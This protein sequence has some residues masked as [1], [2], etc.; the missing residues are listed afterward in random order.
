MINY[1]TSGS[2]ALLR[3]ALATQTKTQDYNDAIAGY[4]YGL[5]AKTEDDFKQYNDYLQ[6]R[7]KTLGPTDPSKALTLQ[8]SSDAA[9]SSYNSAEIGRQTLAVQYGDETNR[10][11]YNKIQDLLSAAISN[12]DDGLAA[13]L[14]ET[15]ATLS[16]TI[17]NEDDAA[18]ASG[19]AGAASAAAAQTTKISQAEASIDKAYQTGSPLMIDGQAKPLN[20]EDYALYQAQIVKAKH[21]LLSSEAQTDPSKAD[22]L[23]KLEDSSDY[24]NLIDSGLVKFDA[25]GKPIPSA[26]LDNLAVTFKQDP[27]TGVISR[28]YGY[29]DPVNGK[30][31]YGI[32]KPASGTSQK[33][34]VVDHVLGDTPGSI[35]GRTKFDLNEALDP[36]GNKIKG[37]SIYNDPIGFS[38]GQAVGSQVLVSTAADKNAY[39]DDKGAVHSTQGLR[40]TLYND[41]NDGQLTQEQGNSNLQNLVNA[42]VYKEGLPSQL[43]EGWQGIKDKASA[44]VKGF[45]NTPLN[46]IFASSQKKQADAA[47]A[48]AEAAA[49]A[50]S[51]KKA[52]ADAVTFRNQVAAQNAANALSNA[53]HPSVLFQPK[54]PVTPIQT[55]N[56][57]A[58]GHATPAQN[59]AAGIAGIAGYD[60]ILKGAGLF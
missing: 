12:G 35:Q 30:T 46:N 53:A 21:D 50:A 1:G 15:M 34:F 32:I 6:G 57:A 45:L 4:T 19:R 20:A 58:V 7:I 47:R 27:H 55:F 36:Q 43:G 10:D 16:K 5:S 48:Q 14:E 24:R 33:G 44:A 52:Q 13:R 9:Y 60:K 56:L 54:A 17:Q 49:Q 59:T 8:K 41:K 37:V 42:K 40:S 38:R 31:Q 2:S 18:A 28:D 29:V 39:T 3:Q 23:A 25:D 11:K 22:D 26:D 51:I